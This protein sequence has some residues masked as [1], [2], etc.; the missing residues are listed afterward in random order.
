[1]EHFES[2]DLSLVRP[3]YSTREVA[4]VLRIGESH[5]RKLIRQGRLGSV[6]LDA[7]RLVPRPALFAFMAELQ[8][9]LE[10][11]HE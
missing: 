6:K 7:R 1:M 9:Q 2:V 10:P 4:D 8:S 5:V 3:Y 11:T